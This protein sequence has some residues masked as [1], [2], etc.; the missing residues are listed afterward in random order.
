VLLCAI[1]IDATIEDGTIGRLVNDDHVNPNS[2]MKVVAVD[3][4]PHLI[5]YSRRPI[6]AGQEIRYHYGPGSFLWREKV[7]V[8][9]YVSLGSALK[10]NKMGRA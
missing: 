9:H 3:G 6:Y 5:L 7:G 10:I 4:D 1:R 8:R 2:Y